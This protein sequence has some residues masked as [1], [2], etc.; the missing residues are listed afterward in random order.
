MACRFPGAAGLDEFWRLLAA[1]E[2]AIT[3]GRPDRSAPPAGDGDA[4]MWGGFL[5]GVDRFDAAFFRIAP[6]EAQLLDPQQRLLLETSWEALEDAGIRPRELRGSRAGVFAGIWNSDYRELVTAAGDIQGNIYPTTGSSFST[7]IGRIAFTLGLTGPAVAV[8]T[9]CSS[10]LVS[11]H[12]AVVALERGEADL[13]LAGGVN[14]I[15]TDGITRMFSDAGML[16]PDGRCKTFDAAA[17]GYVR[18][19]GCGMVVLKRLADAEASAD[20]ILAVIR[21]SAVNQDGASDGLTAPSGPAQEQV[22]AEALERAE[23]PARSVDY[24][25]AHGTGTRLGDVVEAAAA[26]AAYGRGRRRPLLL[27]SVKTN[28]GHLESAAGVAGVIKVVLSMQEGV[29]PKHRNFETLN[30]RIEWDRALLRVTAEAA[31]WPRG[32]GRP[33][34]AGVSSFGFSGTNAHLILEEHGSRAPGRR[35]AA[36]RPFPVAVPE[37]MRAAG[38]LGPRRRRLLPLSARTGEALRELAK[39]YLG[40][41]IERPEAISLADLAWTAGVGRD[42][43]PVRAGVI[44]EGDEELRHLLR[45]ASQEA[46]PRRP[47]GGTVAF[48]F[49]GQGSQSVGMGRALYE[50]EPVFRSILDRCDEVVRAER[51]ASL[52]EVMFEGPASRLDDTAWTQPALYALG[53]AFADMWKSVGVLPQVV[54]GHSVGELAAARAAGAF[55]LEEGLRFA[56]RRGAAMGALP[57]GGAMAAVFAS[58][59]RVREALPGGGRVELAAFNGTH[60]VVSGETGVLEALTAR[61]VSVG[62]RVE[63]LAT[64]HAFHSALMDPA[65]A[66]IEAAGPPL[67]PLSVPLV[68]NVTGRAIRAGETLEPG[69]WRRQARE[70][71]AFRRSVAELAAVGV[72]LSIELG[73]RAVLGPMVAGCW[74][75][76]SAASAPLASQTGEAAREDGGFLAAVAA[77]YEA[78]LG[79]RFEGLY[80]GEE[81]RRIAAP[82]Y[83]FQRE[84]YW[85]EAAKRR[86]SAPGHPVLGV[87]YRAVN[88]EVTYETEYSDHDPSWLADSRVF[89]LPLASGALFAAQAALAGVAESGGRAPGARIEGMEVHRPLVV[90][91]PGEPVRVVRVVLGT[92]GE[93]G[94]PLAIYSRGE[95]ETGW[96]L[97]ANGRYRGE[98]R[99]RANGERVDLDRLRAELAVADGALLYRRLGEAGIECDWACR[100]VSRVWSGA[101][102]AFGEVTLPAGLERGGLPFHPAELEAWFQVAA[103]AGAIGDREA[104]WLPSGWE[105][106]WLSGALPERVVAHWRLREPLGESGD[107]PERLMADLRLYDDEGAVVG[108]TFGCALER[109]ARVTLEGSLGGVSDLLYVPRWRKD[110]GWAGAGGWA[111]RSADF[112]LDPEAVVAGMSPKTEYL[113]AE[114]TSAATEDAAEAERDRLCRSFALSALERLG[115]RRRRGPVNSKRLRSKLGVPAEREAL[116][117]RLFDLLEQGG[118]CEPAAGGGAGRWRAVLGARNPLPEAFADPESLVEERDGDPIE[119]VLLRRC[120]ASLAEVLR[121]AVDPLGLLFPRQ[122]PGAADFYRHAPEARAMN[123]MVADAVAALASNLPEGRRLRVLE[124]GAGTGGTTG[125]ILAALPA[126]R[127][128]YAFTDISAGFFSEAEARFGR[129]SGFSCQALDIER[130][131]VEQGF[132][133][134]RYDIVLAANALHATRDL[135]QTLRH[136]RSLLAP[137]GALVLLEGLR[138]S[139]W[140]DLTFGLLPG[141]W[142]FSDSY[143]TD[144]PLADGPSWRRALADAGF[145]SSAVAEAGPRAWCSGGARPK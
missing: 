72:G 123:R 64:S 58:E 129:S 114:G 32:S 137:S 44:F 104:V 21:G 86:P 48:L 39:R 88:G 108:E 13:A 7:A 33:V 95:S 111:L 42:H 9:A 87:R 41:L 138:R 36:G 54:L 109:T 127:F 75:G 73:P 43:F 52:L 16:S 96:M 71:V 118:V 70:P 5:R 29:I 134:H 1:G 80:A 128:D 78:G 122:G 3:R 18:G 47:A 101:S 25:E 49:P 59:A 110:A 141:W 2:S 105:R 11:M 60:Q 40:W 132:E 100:G 82:G 133:A 113:V 27:G 57:P 8:D 53:A 124:I 81:R 74:P 107:P 55:G 131:P 112:F 144:G 6:V 10:S 126:G 61:L 15:L 68:S 85:I 14:V 121:G 89:G 91:E 51:G 106:F 20:R 67:L 145:V 98:P 93:G 4:P 125:A 69:Y 99:R 37:E 26:A 83:P 17:D 45:L 94:R 22:I 63:R 31:E 28:I 103:V 66:A 139:N 92:G 90:P 84:R 65:L 102:E 142:R 140:L 77:A 120:G 24:L 115:W 35:G 30:P 56:L 117:A 97:H 76:G 116:F 23:L 143:R 119:T 135:G 19:E 130:D 136:C 79:L 50:R 12:Q 34:L 62:V 38:R 46:V